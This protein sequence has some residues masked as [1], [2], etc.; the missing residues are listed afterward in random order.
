MT[1]SCVNCEGACSC[2]VSEICDVY[3]KDGKNCVC[4]EMIYV[5]RK[6]SEGNIVGFLVYVCVRRKCS[7]RHIVV[8]L[9]GLLCTSAYMCIFVCIV[10]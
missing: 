4:V 3:V 7:K 5:C 6:C 2:H 10:V 9:G 8:F 1:P